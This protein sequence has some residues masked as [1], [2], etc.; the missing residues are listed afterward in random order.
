MAFNPCL[1]RL[2]LLQFWPGEHWP[3]KLLGAVAPDLPRFPWA[4]VL[5][6][7]SSVLASG[8]AAVW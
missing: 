3:Q 6:L 2:L 1:Y 7:S 4:R 8:K 5:T